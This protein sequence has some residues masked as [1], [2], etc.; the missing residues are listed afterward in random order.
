MSEQHEKMVF[1]VT[2]AG[3]DPE[4]ATFPLLD[5]QCGPVHGYRGDSGVARRVGI[6]GQEGLCR[7]VH[8][9]R[10]DPAE[11]LL[12]NLIANGGKLLCCIPCLEERK[13]SKD[14]LI[15]GT[16]LVKAGRLIVEMSEAK[17]TVVY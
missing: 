14:E 11:E 12:D 4:R 10:P 7:Q 8:V 15:E 3:E 17:S 9:H 13:I 1:I 6:S 2:H 5:G 16:E